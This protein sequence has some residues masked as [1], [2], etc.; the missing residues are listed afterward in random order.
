MRYACWQTSLMKY[1]TLFFQKLGKMLQNLWSAAV[2]IGAL[3]LIFN[4]RNAC[5]FGI[6]YV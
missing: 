3:R 5:T 2:V 6:A 1:H 4:A